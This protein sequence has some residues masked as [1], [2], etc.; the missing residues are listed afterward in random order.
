MQNVP[1]WDETFLDL[2][3]VIQRRAKC[4]RRKVGALVV[5]GDDPI[6]FGYNGTA[7][8]K[9]HCTEGGCPRGQLPHVEIPPNADYNQFPCKAIHAEANAIIRA[10]KQSRGATLYITCPP[11]LQC[12]N[13]AEGAGIVRI[14]Y[15][16][17]VDEPQ[18]DP[19]EEEL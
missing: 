5:V 1:T 12:R 19:V 10:G 7:S 15:R 17:S 4:T 8:G 6:A 13:L 14:V 9:T 16:P 3:A 2:A 18:G 11:C